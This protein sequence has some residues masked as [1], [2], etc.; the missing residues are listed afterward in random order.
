MSITQYF[1]QFTRA[2][3]DE[4]AAAK[5][6]GGRKVPLTN[7]RYI[8]PRGDDHIYSFTTDAEL[9]FPDDSPIELEVKQKNIKG[10]ILSISQYDLILSLMDY[11][12]DTV[13]F[14]R[15][16]TEPWFLLQKLQER[17]EEIR[18]RAQSRDY[19]LVERLLGSDTQSQKPRVDHA[20]ELLDTVERQNGQEINC[21]LYQLE[22]VAHVLSNQ[23][24]FIWGP[25]GTGKTM[26]LGATV[27]A[28]VAEHKSVLILSHSNVAVDVAMLSAVRNLERTSVYQSHRVLR[29]GVAYLDAVQHYPR[30]HVRGIVRAENPTL[31]KDLEAL[32]EKRRD[33]I[34]RS[35]ADDLTE[36]DKI[37]LKHQL[38][39]IRDGIQP[40]RNQ[41]QQKELELVGQAQVIGCTLSK[42]TIATEI[43]QRQFDAV[44]IDEASMAY[45]PHCA[46]AGSLA[47]ERIAIYGDF[48]QLPPISQAETLLAREWLQ[49][50]IFEHA[51]IV[52]KIDQGQ[53]D[54]RLVL[55]ATQYRMHPH[56]AAVPNRLFYNNYLKNGPNVEQ[57]NAP[58]TEVHPFPG[59]ALV[60]CDLS[61]L[62]NHCY[63]APKS[64]GYSRFNLISALTAVNLAH[65]LITSS[66][67]SVGIITPYNAQARLIRNLLADLRLNRGKRITV[68]TVH[69]F[70]GSEQE[71]IVFDMVEARNNRKP[72][73]L[74]EGGLSSIALRLANVAISRAKGKFILLG[75]RDHIE[76]RFS[77]GDIFKQFALHVADQGAYLGVQWPTSDKSGIWT[78]TLEGFTLHHRTTA[79]RILSDVDEAQS[80]LI[81]SQPKSTSLHI[82]EQ[83]LARWA[84]QPSHALFF[85]GASGN[86]DATAF[87]KTVVWNECNNPQLEVIG[88]DEQRFWIRTQPET[89]GSPTICLD[90]PKTIQLLCDLWQLTEAPD[91]PSARQSQVDDGS[92]VGRRCPECQKPLMPASNRRGQPYLKCSSRFCEY[93]ES[94]AEEDATYLARFLNLKCEKCGGDVAGKKGR[95]APRTV[96]LGC[97]NYPKCDWKLSIA[98]LLRNRPL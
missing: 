65:R 98:D 68:D 73:Q 28:L 63:Y 52:K 78:N 29:Y 62:D 87:P 95:N 66:P 70:Q 69:R 21:N 71:I 91:R 25:P 58:I 41:L 7:G 88:I 60:F 56:I 13:P 34:R 76:K 48:R 43:Y 90:A 24:S 67:Y 42:A 6:L 8:G 64:A 77:A 89:T 2:L 30:L 16:S 12:G 11:V 3:S 27:A 51:G 97:A 33:L 39:K 94:M 82:S 36:V 44:L 54:A 61:E 53:K 84:L 31:I 50:D 49:R 32:E 47:Q 20:R 57:E 92:P 23:V 22:A 10:Y 74:L 37:R 72:G 59:S 35:Q 75:E 79:S 26:T 1:P 93:T 5:A 96:F 15:M 85:T 19:V 86:Y 17:L 40:L 83:K 9:K 81:I 18:V 46:F 14:A 38:A 80:Q 55:L 4:I 45:I